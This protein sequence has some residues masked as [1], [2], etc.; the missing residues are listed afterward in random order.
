MF[1]HADGIIS[2]QYL[3]VCRNH[4]YTFEDE[5]SVGSTLSTTP[6]YLESSFNCLYELGI[7]LGIVLWRKFL[8]DQID[9]ADQYLNALA[10]N[11][12]Q[13]ER[14][15]LAKP[16]LEFADT[17]LSRT[18]KEVYKRMFK[19]NL[20][21]CYKWLK[22]KNKCLECINQSDWSACSDDFQLCVAVLKDDYVEAAK[23]MEKIGKS[24]ALP[25][26]SYEDW[27]IFREFRDQDI[28]IDTFSHIFGHPPKRIEE[29]KINNPKE[30]I[31]FGIEK[32]S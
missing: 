10:Y 8:P 15:S 22:D 12:L 20:A 13:E 23:T 1:V 11:L 29:M 9:A 27:P 3:Q 6:Q 4:N 7:K 14:Y 5:L 21:Q 30:L 26:H 19:I 25:E 28:F 24:N 17:T 18:S 16:I 32:K 31:F 2:D